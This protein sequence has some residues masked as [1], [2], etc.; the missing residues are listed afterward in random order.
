MTLHYLNETKTKHQQK[1]DYF[2]NIGFEHLA[3]DF[4]D[5]VE[6]IVEMENYI[7]E[8]DDGEEV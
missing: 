5:I 7:K 1:S 6:L 3:A 8:K 4:Q 2:K